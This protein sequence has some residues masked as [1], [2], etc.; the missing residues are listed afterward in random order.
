MHQQQWDKGTMFTVDD[1]QAMGLE[2][3]LLAG[4]YRVLAY[5]SGFDTFSNIAMNHMKLATCFLTM[6]QRQI[7][8]QIEREKVAKMSKR[9]T[10]LSVLA[11]LMFVLVGSV[12]AQEGTEAVPVV[13]TV[14]GDVVEATLEPT[15]AP[16]NTE[17]TEVWLIVRETLGEYLPGLG[18]IVVVFVIAI[19]FI[20]VSAIV[21]AGNGMPKWATPIIGAGKTALVSV[22][23]AVVATTPSTFDDEFWSTMKKLIDE[24]W[25]TMN[26]IAAAGLTPEDIDAIR[27]QATPS[28]YFTTPQPPTVTIR[29]SSL[30]PDDLHLVAAEILRRS[31]PVPQFDPDEDTQ[32]PPGN[33]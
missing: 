25:A 24:K 4:Y 13:V 8:A 18:N 9:W 5:R 29:P 26:S 23:D 6:A 7:D 32:S 20:S 33:Q 22:G 2:H 27:A 19:A 16:P 12:S 31:G 30:T 21:V 1:L 10:I 11:L 15:T 28:V 3:E 17:A 14:N